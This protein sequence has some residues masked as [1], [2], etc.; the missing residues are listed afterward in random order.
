[1]ILKDDSPVRRQIMQLSKY[2]AQVI[3]INAGHSKDLGLLYGSMG[4]A[5]YLYNLDRIKDVAEYHNFANELIFNI[6]DKITTTD[7]Y[8]T[9]G[10]TGIAW[11][12]KYLCNNDF[13]DD[14]GIEDL[15]HN[16]DDFCLSNTSHYQLN[17]DFFGITG[18][19]M[20]R[21]DTEKNY[22]IGNLRQLLIKEKIVS[23]LELL[24]SPILSDNYLQVNIFDMVK[25]YESAPHLIIKEINDTC[26]SVLILNLARKKKIYLE[27]VKKAS[28]ILYRK[29]G[30]YIDKLAH[31]L[32]VEASDSTRLFFLTSLSRLYYSLLTLVCD[33]QGQF[34][35][36]FSSLI[37]SSSDQLLR[38]NQLKLNFYDEILLC[39]TLS[40]ISNI[41]ET[42]SLNAFIEKKMMILINELQKNRHL[43]KFVYPNKYPLNLGFTGIAGMGMILLQWLS[44]N[45]EEWD[46]GLLIS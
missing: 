9:S 39:A 28:E 36:N 14:D 40:R 22:D 18:Y 8:Y 11:G 43:E 12:M 21:I 19:L 13:I 42:L 38:S 10:S 41:E 29:I 33:S 44:P 3:L 45:I 7:S 1:M 15:L 17:I 24:T 30:D 20:D 16:F 26:Y 31:L 23:H 4:S 27:I 32:S 2:I 37:E 6:N 46:K 25:S 5:I 34:K 35:F